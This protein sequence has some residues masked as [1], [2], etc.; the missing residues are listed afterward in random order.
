M[1][2]LN[3]A[4]T[5]AQLARAIPGVSV[6]GTVSVRDAKKNDRGGRMKRMATRMPARKPAKKAKKGKK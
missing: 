1:K 3:S 5:A 6:Y 4:V 2:K